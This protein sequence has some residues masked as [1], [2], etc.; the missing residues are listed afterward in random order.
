MA[1]SKTLKGLGVFVGLCFILTSWVQVNRV[2]A[3]VDAPSP[4][5]SKFTAAIGGAERLRFD[6]AVFDTGTQNG[7]AFIQDR[8]GFLWIGTNGRGLLRYDGYE[9]KAYKPGESNSISDPFVYALYEDRDGF[10]W[11]ATSNGLNRYDKSGDT[12]TVYRHDL[13]NPNSLS[14]ST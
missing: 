5:G 14:N 4:I 11:I 3:R 10:I 6:R 1:F 13:D 7:G 8:D 2:Q 12:F 9:L